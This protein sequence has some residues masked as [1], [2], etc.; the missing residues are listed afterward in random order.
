MDCK[1][2]G[3]PFQNVLKGMCSSPEFE[4][5]KRSSNYFRGMQGRRRGVTG[6]GWCYL[7]F[8]VPYQMSPTPVPAQGCGHGSPVRPGTQRCIKGCFG[9]HSWLQ[10]ILQEGLLGSLVLSE[11]RRVT[12]VC[13]FSENDSEQTTIGKCQRLWLPHP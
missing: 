5:E 1:T 9:K 7:S 10:W 6:G 13:H 8:Y 12:L 11:A 3:L 2:Q 4:S